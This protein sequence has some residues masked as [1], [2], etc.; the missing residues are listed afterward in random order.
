MKLSNN[1]VPILSKTEFDAVATNFLEKYY[2]EAL[3]NP[4]AVPIEKIA[5]QVLNLQIKRV[6]LSEDLSILG[7]IFFSPGRTEIYKKDTDEFVHKKVDS[8]MMFIDPDVAM[9]RNIGSENNTI[10]HECVHWHIHRPYH[11]IQT[12][13]GGE[14]A[15]A[16]RCPIEPPSEHLESKWVAEDWMEWHANGIAPRILM[17]K[18][19]YSQYVKQ[20]PSYQKICFGKGNTLLIDHL[21]SELAEFF[22]VS[23]ESALIRLSELELI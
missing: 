12:L 4:M 6:H 13:A 15:V 1:L 20:H 23:R 21:V 16:C 10:A 5:V 11:N 8:G 7:Q 3:I 19:I 2:P 22:Q 14:K 18:D 9:M 17:P